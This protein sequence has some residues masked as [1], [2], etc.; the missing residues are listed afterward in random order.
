MRAHENST[1]W[2]SVGTCKWT[3]VSEAEAKKE[4]KLKLP[5]MQLLVTNNGG[6]S[7]FETILDYW[8]TK[9]S[10]PNQQYSVRRKE[11]SWESIAR[12]V[13]PWLLRLRLQFLLTN[14]RA[15]SG[16]S[17]GR[18]CPIECHVQDHGNQGV[19]EWM[20][21]SCTSLEMDGSHN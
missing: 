10:L 9:P 3:L 13:H 12:K 21:T 14:G 4:I 18:D 17:M 7:L 15:W 5:A 16:T 20:S 1:S 11:A 2:S 6:H 19:A 8:Y